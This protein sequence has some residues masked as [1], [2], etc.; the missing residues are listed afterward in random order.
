[1]HLTSYTGGG[2]DLACERGE[3]FMEL[4]L[5]IGK[6]GMPCEQLMVGRLDRAKP[7]CGFLR[8]CKPRLP[9]RDFFFITRNLRA[10]RL[11]AWRDPGALP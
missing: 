3:F 1:M 6:L 7:A 8:G 4:P 5:P 9:L 2:Y 11:L 10:Q